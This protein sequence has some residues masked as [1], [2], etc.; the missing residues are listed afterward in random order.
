[1]K[2]RSACCVI[3]FGPGDRGCEEGGP[4]RVEAVAQNEEHFFPNLDD[5]NW[6]MSCHGL[7]HIDREDMLALREAI[8]ESRRGD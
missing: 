4:F 2:R 3:E 5:A 1:M 8:R 7:K 6:F